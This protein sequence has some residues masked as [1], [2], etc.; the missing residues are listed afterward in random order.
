MNVKPTMKNKQIKKKKKGKNKKSNLAT[1][2]T[3][4]ASLKL[5]G[6]STLQKAVMSLERERERERGHTKSKT[7]QPNKT[8]QTFDSINE[9]DE[10]APQ[11]QIQKL[12]FINK[13]KTLSVNSMS[14]CHQLSVC[15]FD[16]KEVWVGAGGSSS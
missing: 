11:K 8:K 9:N 4:L 12:S 2:A 1:V 15:V 6:I 10:E 3:L 13:I 7:K 16:E 14:R 5:F